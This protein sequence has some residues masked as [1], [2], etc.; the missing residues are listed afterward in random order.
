MRT[1]LKGAMLWLVIP[2]A[3]VSCTPARD[4]ASGT[5][6]VSQ[7]GLSR[8]AS[9]SAI[10]K[11]LELV[12]TAYRWIPPKTVY[13]FNTA[14]DFAYVVKNPNAGIGTTST[15][16][17]IEMLDEGGT[18]FF[19]DDFEI[20]P[21]RPGE[22]VDGGCQEFPDKQPAT[23]RF[24]LAPSPGAWLPSSE[25]EPRGFK[26]LQ[27]EGFTVG[28][29]KESPS[30]QQPG[31]PSV[32]PVFTM[33]VYNPNS[34][35]F[36]VFSVDV[37]RRDAGGKIVAYYGDVGDRIAAGARVPFR[38]DVPDAFSPSDT[39]EVQARPWHNLPVEE[40]P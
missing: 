22:T 34:V 16:L 29:K 24:R 37:L 19:T 9:G 28:S 21:V 35:G 36:R 38:I 15:T 31:F 2:L 27:A 8:D 3:L 40:G 7:S 5:T 11:P 39:F 12:E 10:P 13:P 25:W 33:R 17:R 23:V 20:G 30:S 4:G 18:T 6:G 14:V 1:R 32:H 26:P